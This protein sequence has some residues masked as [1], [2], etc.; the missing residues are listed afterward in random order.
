[1]IDNGDD[2]GALMN[3]NN[4]W[5]LTMDE[6]TQLILFWMARLEGVD[7]RREVAEIVDKHRQVCKY[8]VRDMHFSHEAFF[9]LS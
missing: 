4:L 3:V 6:R 8:C 9:M 7:T 1:M 2:S 5:K